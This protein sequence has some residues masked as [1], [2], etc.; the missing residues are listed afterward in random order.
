[1]AFVD[2]GATA[3][4]L[5]KNTGR[6][7][8]VAN[9]V[10]RRHRARPARR[11]RLRA[12]AARH[13]ALARRSRATTSSTSHYTARR[14]ST[15][16]ARS[17]TAS[18]ATAGTA[19]TLDAHVRP[20]HPRHAR[21][22]PG[23]NH[24]GGKIAFGPDGKLYADDRRPQSQ[25]ADE[26]LRDS[27]ARQRAAARSSASTRPARRSPP[28][29][30]TTRSTSA[31]R[32]ALNDI[33]A[34]GVRNSFGIA[35][36]PRQ[37]RPVGHGERP[38]PHG[39]DQPRRP[40]V[41][42]RLAGR[43]GPE[44]RATAA[45]SAT[46][47]SLGPARALRGPAAAAGT[48]RSRRPTRTSWRRAASAAQYKHDLFVGTVLGGGVIYQLRP[49]PAAARRSASPAARSPTA[50]PTTPAA[51]CSP[52]R[53]TSSSARGFGV[54]TDMLAGPGG[55]YVLSLTNGVMYRITTTDGAAIRRTSRAIVGAVPTPAA[56]ARG[57]AARSRAAS[58]AATT[59][60]LRRMRSRSSADA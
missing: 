10:D 13:R 47:V 24:D 31:R 52:S 33:Y 34:Y 17:T 1:M 20:Q 5:E 57:A 28:T 43:H 30:S 56:G 27:G 54:V 44:Q 21:R 26:Q 45:A 23:P 37:R 16:A 25:R 19:S 32:A 15:A 8:I 29:R 58:V 39:R 9:R 40:R 2:G 18:S 14:P 22:R 51:T 35:F 3:L 4:V 7:Q 6:V 50:S 55:M 48:S 12:R 59:V 60:L 11:E 38:G 42:Q 49:E 53:P 46:L 36:D 41:Q